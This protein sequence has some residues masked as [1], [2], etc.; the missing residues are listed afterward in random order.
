MTLETIDAKVDAL[1]DRAKA[2]G[3]QYQS[4]YANIGNDS[5]LSEEGKRQARDELRA[6]FKP[7]M[8]ELREREKTVVGEAIES[9][10]ARI[11]S[12]GSLTSGDVIS[13]RDA[14]DRAERVQNADEA[15]QILER[16]LRQ[17][18]KTL[19]HA[20]LRIGIDKGYTKVIDTFAAK[21]PSIKEVIR[22]LR[23]LQSF[24]NDTMPRTLAYA[25][26]LFN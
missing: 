20:V 10:L 7:Q 2:L 6:E 8:T 13:F 26:D 15:V 11:E 16:A 19:A 1:R 17:K 5:T 3:K 25:L 23:T 9:R 12:P 22:E 24:L 4:L 14:Q 21:D 18:D